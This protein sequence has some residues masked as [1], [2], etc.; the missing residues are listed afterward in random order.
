MKNREQIQKLIED[1][2]GTPKYYLSH[3]ALGEKEVTKQEFIKAER[4]AGFRPK[5]PSTHP[6]YMETC[7]T[8]GFSSGD[9]RG[10]IEYIKERK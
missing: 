8:G 6:N 5:L 9:M 3:S 2:L 10:R 1:T 4:A 7:A